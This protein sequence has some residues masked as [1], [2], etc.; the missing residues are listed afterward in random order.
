[1]DGGLFEEALR[2]KIQMVEKGIKPDVFTY[3]TLFSGFEKAGK[4][5]ITTNLQ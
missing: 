2:L 3:T 5:H 1:M 4:D